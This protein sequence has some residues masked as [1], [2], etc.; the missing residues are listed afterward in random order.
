MQAAI[1]TDKPEPV[2]LGDL[3]P[4]NNF[5]HAEYDGW[6]FKVASGN[7][8]LMDSKKHVLVVVE[9]SGEIMTLRITDL[10]YPLLEP[11]VRF[12]YDFD[13]NFEKEREE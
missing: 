11:A 6:V 5:E 2:E 3:R 8:K 4:G 1:H 10:V 13:R 9:S 12:S 7:A